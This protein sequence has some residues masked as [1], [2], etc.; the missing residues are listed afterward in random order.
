[1]AAVGRHIE[2]VL[3]RP[4]PGDVL[5]GFTRVQ[6]WAIADGIDPI[7]LSL[8]IGESLV[9]DPP[10]RFARPDV[11]QAYP[12]FSGN[13][14]WPGFFIP[15]ET[16][17]YPDGPHIISLVAR[18]SDDWQT[19]V[20]AAVEICNRAF[21]RVPYARH[22]KAF[23]EAGRFPGRQDIYR[24]GPPINEPSSEVIEL[25]AQNAGPRILDVGCGNGVYVAAYRRAG[26]DCQGVEFDPDC[27]AECTR[28]GV[29]AQIMDAHQLEFPSGSFDTVT[30]IEVLE[31]LPEPR[32]AI[33][34]AFRV[35]RRNVII[36]VPNIDVL[37]I[38]YAYRIV[39]WHLLEA[40]HVNFFTP[41][42]LRDALQPF[43]KSVTVFGRGQF[44]AWIAQGPLYMNL[45]AVASL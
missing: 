44:A 40:T 14:P 37:P 32:R 29:P 18:K 25:V 22:L 8:K 33:A 28:R 3:D 34:E 6:G 26:F 15:L 38:M 10:Q 1:V 36:S 45:M 35:A 7:H 39:P 31:H 30:M 4:Q 21:E 17:D 42:L 43:A 23:E 2:A 9:S 11:H 13:N 12:S 19:I 5:T 24:S 20:C 27:V 41:R 16:R